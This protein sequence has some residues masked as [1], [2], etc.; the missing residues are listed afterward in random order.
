M[1]SQN[2]LGTKRFDAEPNQND[3]EVK[4]FDK[5]PLFPQNGALPRPVFPSR[6]IYVPESGG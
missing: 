4:P 6:H 1:Q 3:A 2:D 5:T